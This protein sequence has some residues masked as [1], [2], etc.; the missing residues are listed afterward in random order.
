VLH[1]EFGFPLP[2]ESSKRH[3]RCVLETRSNGTVTNRHSRAHLVSVSNS[4]T[5]VL[6][7][8]FRKQYDAG[9]LFFALIA[10][11]CIY[12]YTGAELGCGR[13]A[14]ISWR[15]ILEGVIFVIINN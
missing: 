2:P 14:F 7:S 9:F 4:K 13:R 5:S 15:T 8:A 6:F 11:G 12:V 3:Y 1:D 10:I